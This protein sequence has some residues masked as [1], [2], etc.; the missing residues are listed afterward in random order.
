MTP[1]RA[2]VV[3][4][5]RPELFVPNAAGR[6]YPSVSMSKGG[7][8]DMNINLT[9]HIRTIDATG[10]DALL[11]QHARTFQKHAAMWARKENT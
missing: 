10:M 3:G 9:S 11:T 8:G 2:Y 1:G 4:E 5:K 6:I 7:A